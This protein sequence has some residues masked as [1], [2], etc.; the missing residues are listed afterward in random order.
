MSNC[1]E[2]LNLGVIGCGRWGPNHVRVFSELD[3]SCVRACADPNRTRLERLGRRF[4]GVRTVTDYRDLLS[5]GAIDAVVIA[6][7]TDTHAA[8]SLAALRAG[9]HVLVEKPLSVTSE[10]AGGLARAADATGLVLM[11]GHVFLFN[12]GIMKLRELM[13]SGELGRI[14]YLDAVRT[15]LGPIRPDVNA[16]YDL[17]THDIS[18]FNYLL[19]ATP[20]GVSALGSCISQEAIEDVCFATLKYPD[21]TLGHIHVSWMNPRKVRTLTV[22]GERQMAH[23]DDVDPSDALRLYDKGIEE[24]PHC[25]SFGEFQYLLRNADVYLP[26][27]DRVEPLVNQANAFL[28]TV[29]KGAPCRSGPTEAQAVVAVLEAASLSIREAGRMCPVES[30]LLSEPVCA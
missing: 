14:H 29:L 19:G 1:G 27:I 22:V 20:V 11:V 17:A 24:P 30:P 7:P 5:D 28:D 2:M 9:K 3:R 16:L 18:I 21:G 8:I 25:D 4:P 10:E 23:W 12:N 6:T 15:N 26:Q 13:V